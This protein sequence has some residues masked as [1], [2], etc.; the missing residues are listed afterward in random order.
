MAD[1][2]MT[3]LVY[4]GEKA[5]LP[6]NRENSF[7]LCTDTKELYFGNTL[8]T[9]AVRI[10]TISDTSKP[11]NPAQG[12]LYVDGTSGNGYSYDGSAWH[13]LFTGDAGL[14]AKIDDAIE[15]ALEELANEDAAV[16][17]QFVT[18]VK[19]TDGKVEVTRRALTADDIPD[20]SMDKIT[21][22]A[23][24]LA[25]KADI[26]ESGDAATANTIY[27]AKKHADDAVE[28]AKTALIGTDESASTTDTIKGAKKY[29]DEQIA[30]KTSSVY[31]PGGSKQF[32][33]LAD[34]LEDETPG[35]VYNITDADGFTTDT[36]FVEGAGKH[37]PV[38]TNVV[39]VDVSG[40]NKWDV[41]AGVVDLTDYAK[42]NEVASDIAAAKTALIGE[43]EEGE[44]DATTIKDAVKEAKQY[45][46]DTVQDLDVGDLTA[47]VAAIEAALTVGT[48]P[49]S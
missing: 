46:D 28:A 26:G 35:T 49:E 17:K 19:Q 7:Y 41:L 36:T 24:A 8:Y 48:F 30:A 37:Y 34:L 23:D 18:V 21:D 2:M 40:T 42:K 27:G 22:L 12:V 13:K 16:D 32:S 38:G 3:K 5:K 43:D 29:T 10:T 9:E 4:I 6:Q 1:S 45:V 11:Q 31:K 47:R 14:D 44:V 20:L 33:E 25:D 15:A 39:C